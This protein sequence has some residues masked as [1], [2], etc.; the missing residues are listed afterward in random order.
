MTV[1]EVKVVK[2]VKTKRKRPKKSRLAQ[3]F[4]PR[5]RF[6]E[7]LKR[8]HK[9]GDET[10]NVPAGENSPETSS[11]PMSFPMHSPPMSMAP[12]STSSS[13]Q[14]SPVPGPS[15][16][17]RVRERHVQEYD[18]ESWDSSSESA[19]AMDNL[20][21]AMSGASIGGEVGNSCV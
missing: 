9:G 13:S 20:A 4:R 8:Y 19:A 6:E 21:S 11:P 7:A 15:K 1:G 3:R 2:M 17:R 12:H 5:N 14:P 16:R 10:G 18:T